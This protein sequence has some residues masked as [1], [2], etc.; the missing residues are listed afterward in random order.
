MQLFLGWVM[1]HHN[2]S[3]L[4]A[5]QHSLHKNDFEGSPST[6][7]Q[8]LCKTLIWPW[9]LQSV[10]SPLCYR[11]GTF[12]SLLTALCPRKVNPAFWTA[13]AKLWVLEAVGV[14]AHRA[15][16]SLGASSLLCVDW[17]SHKALSRGGDHS[18]AREMKKIKVF[19]TITA[20]SD[21]PNRV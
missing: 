21:D 18:R 3:P 15:E 20:L 12:P 11:N 14:C 7:Y 9:Q 10:V 16:T 19:L 8:T 4:K 1:M 5:Q 17:R 13:S 6:R 2:W